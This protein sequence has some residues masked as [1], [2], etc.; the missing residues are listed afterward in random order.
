MKEAAA[1]QGKPWKSAFVG[2]E[3]NAA[4]EEKERQRL[5]LERFQEEV[6]AWQHV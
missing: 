3:I 6:R 2:H 4:D 5:L 1:V